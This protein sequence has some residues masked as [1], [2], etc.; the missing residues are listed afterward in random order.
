MAA[1]PGNPLRP[2][3]ITKAMISNLAVSPSDPRRVWVTFGGYEPEIKV[4]E[5][6][7]GG[8]TWSN[9]SPGLPNV[10]ANTVVAQNVP[11]HGI[12]VG[13]DSGVYYRDDNLGRWVP[14]K[15]HLPGVIISSLQ[16]DDAR[17]RLFAGT[18]GR[19]VWQT[20]IPTSATKPTRTL[21]TKPRIEA[22]PAISPEPS[23][24]GPLDVF[25]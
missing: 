9:I 19:G 18:F 22:A 21:Q 14:F 16:L 12:F 25:E 5:T 3:P 8:S 11:A 24:A 20:D 10:P 1:A 13:N 6:K 17:G 7:D 15:D 23:Y 4:F 2:L